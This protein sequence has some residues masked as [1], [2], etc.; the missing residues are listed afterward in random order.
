MVTQANTTE[1]DDLFG[2]VSKMNLYI[3]VFV[4]RVATSS[5]DG[6]GFCRSFYV[7]CGVLGRF[8]GFNHK[9]I[10]KVQKSPPSIMVTMNLWSARV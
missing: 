1:I 2:D 9:I 6:G 10:I 3:V 7:R 8:F 5:G 4:A